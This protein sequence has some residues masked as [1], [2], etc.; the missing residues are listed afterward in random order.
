[1]RHTQHSQ[2]FAVSQQHRILIV[3]D[4]KSVLFAMM[5]YFT[6]HGFAVDCSPDVQ[7]AER[8]LEAHRYAAVITDLQLTAHNDRHGL[9]L[10]TYIRQRWP[11]TCIILLTADTSPQVEAEAHWRGVDALLC[12][13]KS[14]S[15]VE[16]TVRSL[17][18]S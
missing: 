4:E 12:K 3:D 13:P 18:A 16:Q 7:R 1:M 5:E 10:I 14:L 6:H 17:L 9:Q 11:S 2:S 15:E 8:L